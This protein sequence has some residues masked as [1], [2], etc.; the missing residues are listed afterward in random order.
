MR[1]FYAAAVIVTMSMVPMGIAKAQTM[2]SGD[3]VTAGKTVYLQQCSDCHSNQPHVDR[4][5]P[6]LAGVYGRVSGTAPLHHYSAAMKAAH[7]V[8]DADTL[9][10]FLENPRQNIHGTTMPYSGLASAS[11]RANVI[12]YL[13]SISP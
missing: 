13:K 3:N 11:A 2:S 5:G 7:I 1:N 6:T 9:D 10:D 4:F 8:W 12:A